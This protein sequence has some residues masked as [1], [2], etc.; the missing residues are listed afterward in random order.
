MRAKIVSD[1]GPLITLE[2]LDGGYKFIRKLY[3]TIIIPPKVL[4]EVSET[5]KSPQEYL[6]RYHIED[7]I[8][9]HEVKEISALA[10]IRRLDEGE[11]M[12]ISLAFELRLELLIEEVKGRKIARS[13][14]LRVSGIAG[15]IGYAY[16]QRIIEKEEA[17]D[18]LQQLL[19]LGR[20][21]QDVYTAVAAIL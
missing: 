17:L 4:E 7:L 16:R 18:K 1:T 5:T 6:R 12:A 15:Q 19:G 10:G 2:K 3:H 13:A 11:V 20:I 14:G 9:V 8:E 21:N